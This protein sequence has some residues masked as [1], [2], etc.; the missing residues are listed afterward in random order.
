MLA[1]GVILASDVFQSG[2]GVERCCSAACCW[3]SHATSCSPGSASAPRWRQPSTLGGPGS[4][5]GST[6][7]PQSALGVRGRV[8]RRAAGLVA[9]VVVGRA[10]GARSAARGGA[11]RRPGR[12]RTPLDRPLVPWQAASV[13][14]VAAEG[15]AGLMLSVELNAPPGA[16]IATLAGAVFAAHGSGRA[17]AP[18]LR[19]VR[20]RGR[21][22]GARCSLSGRAANA[23]S[24]EVQVVATTTQV[25]DWVRTVAGGRVHR[26]PD[27]AAQHRPARVRAAARRR[28]GAGVRRR[29][30]PQRRGP[31]RL[32][33]RGR[34][35]RRQRRARRPQPGPAA[36]APR[37][38]ELDPHWWHDPRNVGHAVARI[39]DTFARA[40]PS[41][42]GQVARRAQELRVR[43]GGRPRGRA[44][45]AQHP[46][47]PRKLVTDHDAFG[48]FA[49]AT[50]ST[51]SA[52]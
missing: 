3:S 27:P 16:T 22:R 24:S 40:D 5:A 10:G 39:A 51:S 12:D 15:I 13:V 52:R 11:G 36:P 35:G 9:L 42:A 4:R 17:L 21:R 48:Y 50:A 43:S 32:G 19:R 20:G 25:G 1:L 26:A 30:L 29:D 44:L 23:T 28:R 2:S 45:H 18:R 31:R 37:D 41:R 34:Q 7:G 46:A 6:P 38:G 33:G 14:L 8:R 49:G 47:A